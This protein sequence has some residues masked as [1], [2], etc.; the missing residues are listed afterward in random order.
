MSLCGCNVKELGICIFMAFS[1]DSF[2]I[3]CLCQGILDVYYCIA[4]FNFLV[5]LV[6]MLEKSGQESMS[7]DRG[8]REVS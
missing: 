4:M 2:A 7:G 8:C 3:V 1:Y 6:E 5:S